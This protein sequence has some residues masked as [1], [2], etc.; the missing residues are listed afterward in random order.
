MDLTDLSARAV[1][2]CETN[3]ELGNLDRQPELV[4]D[5][6]RGRSHP[7]KARTGGRRH[8]V[9]EG[10]IDELRCKSGKSQVRRVRKAREQI[11]LLAVRPSMSC[12][13]SPEAQYAVVVA[14]AMI[15]VARTMT[16]SEQ[17][18]KLATD[19][20]PSRQ[21]SSRSFEYLEKSL[22][23]NALGGRVGHQ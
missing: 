20:T 7:D 15:E 13:P 23:W 3:G 8:A 2:V 11:R 21:I 9:L 12:R 19:S 22:G 6:A 17:R 10:E 16:L 5:L 1:Q 18:G 4:V 14:S